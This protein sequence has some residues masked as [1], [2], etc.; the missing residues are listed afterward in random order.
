MWCP[1]CQ[2]DVS[3]RAD[4]TR[5]HLGC[6]RCGEPLA[7]LVALEAE[8][9]EPDHL[10]LAELPEDDLA[11]LRL[12]D[13]RFAVPLHLDDFEERLR[14]AQWTLQK[15][16]PPDETPPGEE[17]PRIDA[18][19]PWPFAPQYSR[20]AL[21]AATPPT[22]PVSNKNPAGWG[23]LVLGVAT[24]VCGAILLGWS[25]LAER[26]ELW[27]LG[28]PITLAGQAGLLLGLVMLLERLSQE[29][30][31]AADQIHQLDERFGQLGSTKE[32]PWPHP[33]SGQAFYKHLAE[34]AKPE[35]LLNDLQRQLELLALRVADRSGEG[36]HR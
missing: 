2:Q 34:G 19:A 26:P 31:S 24:F 4:T 22:K 11:E 13:P 17:L 28:V 5:R 16:V 33:S 23:V 7:S 12:I 20:R 25:Y 6:G 8:A 15:S 18:S 36:F 30:R 35:L 3:A 21:P 9:V 32:L 10:A 27:N 1:S 14:E 29:N